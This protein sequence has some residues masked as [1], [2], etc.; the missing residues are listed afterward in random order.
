VRI[1]GGDGRIRDSDTLA[2]R[3]PAHGMREGL[4]ALRR[5][6][7]PSSPYR[8]AAIAH[9]ENPRLLRSEA[10]RSVVS[11]WDARWCSAKTPRN[12]GS[13]WDGRG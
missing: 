3:D 2:P 4:S 6:A 5:M 11:A 10:V 13:F 12:R 7:S 9:R 8:T 1:R